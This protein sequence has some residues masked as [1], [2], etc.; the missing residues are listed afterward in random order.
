VKRITVMFSGVSTSGTSVP[1]IQLGD[2]GGVENTGYSAAASVSSSATGATYTAGF[3]ILSGN[4]SASFVGHVVLTLLNSNR[5]V[6]SGVLGN[7]GNTITH[8][9]GGAKEL[10]DTLTQVRITTTNGTD[11][12]D[13]GTINIM[14]E[15]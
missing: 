8:T 1:L 15:G 13:A 3:G 14:Y 9:L 4:A 12:F 7:T 2:S 5:W 11:T 10:S 6:C